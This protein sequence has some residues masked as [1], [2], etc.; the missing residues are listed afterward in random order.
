MTIYCGLMDK[1]WKPLD[2][3]PWINGWHCSRSAVMND[4]GV[5]TLVMMVLHDFNENLYEFVLPLE[6]AQRVGWDLMGEGLGFFAEFTDKD[7]DDD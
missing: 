3:L 5:G 6:V 4:D 1:V 2:E 7:D